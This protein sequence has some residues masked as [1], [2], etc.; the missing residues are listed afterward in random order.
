MGKRNQRTEV[1]VRIGGITH[2]E[3]AHEFGHPGDE[4]VVEIARHD[5][6]GGRR[7]VLP[8]IDQRPGHRAVHGRIEVGVIENDER[9]L[10]AEFQLGAPTVNGGR[11]HDLS[12]DGG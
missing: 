2:N 5:R 7:A 4:V 11:R 8:G 3:F 9:C 10:A 12:A 6:A 1:G